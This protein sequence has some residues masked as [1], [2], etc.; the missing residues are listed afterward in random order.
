[1]AKNEERIKAKEL[2]LLGKNQ[3][4]IAAALNVQPKTIGQWVKKYGWKNE[5]DARLGSSKSQIQNIKAIISGLAEDR[6]ALSNTIKKAK[7][8]GDKELIQESQKEISKIDNAAA[9]WNKALTNLD[10]EN[11][12]SLSVYLEVM[13]DIF[14]ALQ[15]HNP[16]LFMKTIEFQEQ[17]LSNIS[18]R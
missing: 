7:E 5:R 9:Y 6:I 16:K 17:H 4:E 10:K 13:D 14:K 15:K 8:D 1:M 18:L 2:F 11:R 12:I 3:N